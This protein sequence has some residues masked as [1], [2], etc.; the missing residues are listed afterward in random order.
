M[1]K[2]VLNRDLESLPGWELVPQIIQDAYLVEHLFQDD[3]KIVLELP[4]NI[5]FTPEE[6][7]K[8]FILGKINM[9]YYWHNLVQYLGISWKCPFVPSYWIS[10]CSELVCSGIIFEQIQSGLMPIGF[11]SPLNEREKIYF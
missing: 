7:K 5:I 11:I 2:A 6:Q 9:Y 1:V 10:H 8:L 3:K 4:D